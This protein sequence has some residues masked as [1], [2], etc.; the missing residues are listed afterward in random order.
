MKILLGHCFYR[1]SAPSGEDSAYKNEKKLLLDNGLD[2][3]AYE[4]YNDELSDQGLFKK[5]KT[6]FDY[7][8]S[9]AAYDETSKIIKKNKPDIAHFHNIFPQMSASVY[10]ACQDNQ[11]PV[12]QTLHNYRYLCTNGVFM[13][14]GKPCEDCLS[15]TLLSS[16]IHGCYRESRI[17]TLPMAGMI[18]YNRFHNNFNNLVD[19]YIALT[20]FAKAKFIDGGIAAKKIHVKPNFVSDSGQL[21][22]NYGNYIVYVGRLSSEK[23]V[24]T[25]FEAAKKFK[26]IPLKIIGD[27][28]LRMQLETLQIQYGLNIEFLG[29]QQKDAVISAIKRSRFL[30][31]PSECYEGFPVTIAEAFSCAKPVI[32]SDIGSLSEIIR[33]DITG[34]KFLPGSADALAACVNQLWQDTNKIAR[35]ADFAR[36]EYDEYFSPA[37]N[38]SAL[39]SIYRMLV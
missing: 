27:G 21:E 35:M 36:A 8:W 30:V 1:S 16:V 33:D 18:A 14:N 31:L 23:G 13:R 38:I 39:L 22:N 24:K 37:A 3:I 4:K 7:I 32:A 6:G 15:K 26:H 17:A 28:E 10:Q 9:A 12:I 25:L 2:I 11:V 34:K 29:Y 5:I 20:E 19:T